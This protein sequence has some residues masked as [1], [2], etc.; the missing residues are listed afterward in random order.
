[1][2]GPDE[3]RGETARRRLGLARGLDLLRSDSNRLILAALRRRPSTE[4]ELRGWLALRGSGK[5]RRHLQALAA[6]R[7]IERRAVRRVERRV[8]YRLTDLGDALLEVSADVERWFERHPD[9]GEEAWGAVGW[10]AFGALIDAW[11]G[12]VVKLLAQA[13]RTAAELLAATGISSA[14]LN[15]DLV[16]LGGVGVIRA[17]GGTNPTYALTRWGVLGVGALALACQRLRSVD[18]RSSPLTV[19]DVLTGLAAMLPLARLP[20][21]VSGACALTVEPEAGEGSVARA[22]ALRAEVRAGSVDVGAAAAGQP[23]PDAWLRGSAG[24]WLVAVVTGRTS[25][26]QVGGDRDLAHSLLAAVRAA[27]Y[28]PA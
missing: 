6:A 5:L 18:Q 20:W 19:E 24:D 15:L 11:V 10:R 23:A 12:G 3:D 13:P 16:A 2:L 28:E 17:A 14:R 7:A 21:S 8:E 22:G 26:L 1:M 27:V 4:A 25:A 9:R